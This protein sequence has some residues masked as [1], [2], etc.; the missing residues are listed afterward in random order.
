MSLIAIR[1]NEVFNIYFFITANNTWLSRMLF[2]CFSEHERITDNVKPAKVE[3][4]PKRETLEFIFC[5]TGLMGAYLVW[6][7]LQEKIMTQVNY[8][9]CHII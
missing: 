8:I 7:L 2:T 4:S 3:E 6:G 1:E 5:L 9:Y